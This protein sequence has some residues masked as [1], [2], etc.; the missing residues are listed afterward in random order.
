ML[1]MHVAGCT[2]I[3]RAEAGQCQFWKCFDADY[4]TTH[5]GKRYT[6]LVDVWAFGVLMYLLMYGPCLSVG[7]SVP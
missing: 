2:G 7:Q 5:A 1:C 4:V 6:E 3:D